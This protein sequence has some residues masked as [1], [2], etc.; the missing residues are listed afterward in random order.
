MPMI[1]IRT[2]CRHSYTMRTAMGRIAGPLS[3][4]TMFDRRGRR[5]ST[6]M[7]I[8]RN[9]FTSDTASA[10]A[11]SAALAIELMSVT[12]GV[13][14]GMTGSVVTARTARTTSAGAV[15]A[16]AE[17]DAAFLDVRAR[18]VQ[19]ER[20]DAFDVRQDRRQLH[21]FLDGRSADIHDDDGAARAKLRH[22]FG[23]ES[24]DADA[25]QADR[26]QHSRGRLHDPRRRMAFAL[27]EE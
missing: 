18:D 22:L 16:A 26:V 23:D 9:V 5:V 17:R 12:F 14:F 20:G 1:G 8:A 21:V 10:P 13:S 15:D 4:P 7:A 2:A 25:L 3:P 27:R 11:S 19:L 24:M 6:S